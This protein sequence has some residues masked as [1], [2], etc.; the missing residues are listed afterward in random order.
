MIQN[1]FIFWKIL[2]RSCVILEYWIKSSYLVLVPHK[3]V[4]S[5]DTYVP[6]PTHFN[7]FRKTCQGWMGWLQSQ[8][9]ITDIPSR[10]WVLIFYNFQS[11]TFLLY[12]LV[13]IIQN[14]RGYYHKNP[15]L[16]FWQSSLRKVCSKL[17][18]TSM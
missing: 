9:R 18:D 8:L 13:P 7:I 11:G 4:K 12:N 15:T 14:I 16:H 10:C 5:P 3:V 1:I 6:L 17:I 2:F